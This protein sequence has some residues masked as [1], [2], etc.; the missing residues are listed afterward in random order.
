MRALARSNGGGIPA[1][2]GMT[3]MGALARPI[4]GGIPAYAGMTVTEEPCA[5][6]CGNCHNSRKPGLDSF[7]SAM[8]SAS[9]SR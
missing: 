3:G 7:S 5:Y 4:G 2:A 1:Y 8:R 9:R 6:P